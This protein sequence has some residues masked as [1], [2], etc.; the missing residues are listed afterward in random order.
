M[1]LNQPVNPNDDSHYTYLNSIIDC[2]FPNPNTE[3]NSIAFGMAITLNY[4]DPIKGINMVPSEIV[5]RMNNFLEK[6]KLL[7]VRNCKIGKI[8][9]TGLYCILLY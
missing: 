2:V 7:I 8:M 1:K 5:E 4:L 9:R 3:K 6:C